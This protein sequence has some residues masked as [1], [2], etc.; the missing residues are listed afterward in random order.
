MKI[1]TKAMFALLA[2]CSVSLFTWFSS[3]A[4]NQIA[5]SQ[6]DGG[7]EYKFQNTICLTDEQR[8]EIKRENERSIERLRAQGKLP[9]RDRCQ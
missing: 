3:S 4:E 2:L 5:I 1:R 7:G 8:A 9:E 6:A